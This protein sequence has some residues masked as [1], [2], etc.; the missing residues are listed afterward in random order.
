[1]YAIVDI[2]DKQFKVRDGETLYVPHQRE[3][4]A[5]DLLTFERVLLV[6]DEDGDVTV[7]TPTV[8][9]ASVTARV[10]E[11]V[12]GDKVIVFKKKR[13]KRYRKKKGHRQQYTQ[14]RVEDLAVNGASENGASENATPES[15][16]TSDSGN[17]ATAEADSEATD[18]ARSD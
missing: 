6:S 12:K 10:T 17:A 16:N 1:M 3:A 5:D 18:E 4:E 9:D 14:I 7:G 2:S 15:G 13:R 11:H 8:E